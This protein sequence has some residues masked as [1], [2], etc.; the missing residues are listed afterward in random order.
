[1]ARPRFQKSALPPDRSHRV[2][3]EDWNQPRAKLIQPILLD[4]TTPVGH[5]R[6]RLC[7]QKTLM[8]IVIKSRLLFVALF[9]LSFR[10]CFAQVPSGAVN[11]SFAAA[12]APIWDL[13][14]T[15][16][17]N[18]MMLG[19]GGQNVPLSFSINITHDARGRLR[20]SGLDEGITILSINNLSV[21]ANYTVTGKVSGGGAATRV[22]LVVR[23]TGEDTIAAI[24]TPFTIVITYNL[25]I[26]EGALV[27]K[28]RGSAR[29]KKLG[30][31]GRINDPNIS[32]PLPA[33]MDGSW[34]ADM[35]I[36]PLDKFGGSGSIILSNGR[37]LPAS[38]SGS[39]SRQSL[40]ST[41][42]I[43]GINE[44]KGSSVTVRF[45]DGADAPQSLRGSILGQT[46]RQ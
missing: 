35:N 14:G 29:F 37:A 39:F 16:Q 44:A 22:S 13:T 38:L 11:F 19:A 5:P 8:R 34:S 25:Q 26:Q 36:V 46:L 18:Q 31:G 21:A 12:D 28:S 2:D 41:V 1:M 20:G 33:G 40:V 24:T 17:V 45:L 4:E 9:V 6:V 42:K 7:R 3:W 43:S 27:G 30:G 23:L 15:L 32:L 10:F